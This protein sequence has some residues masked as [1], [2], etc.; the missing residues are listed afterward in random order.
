MTGR[1]YSERVLLLICM[2]TANRVE[3][4]SI[5]RCGRL[6]SGSL[7]RRGTLRQKCSGTSLKV[8]SN[9]SGSSGGETMILAL[10]QNLINGYRTQ[11]IFE[12]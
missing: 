11:L 9:V 1:M 8:K 2:R 10:D 7:N 3:Q 5:S 6:N 12:K 4:N